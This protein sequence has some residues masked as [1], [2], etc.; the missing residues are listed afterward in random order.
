[1]FLRIRLTR[2]RSSTGRVPRLQRGDAGSSPAVSTFRPS[3]CQRPARTLRTVEAQVRLLP[4][5]LHA[6][7]KLRGR[8]PSCDGG[9][10]WFESSRAYSRGR[11]SMESAGPPARRCRFDSGRPLRQACGVTAS[12]ASSNLAGPGSTPG[13]PAAS[14]RRGPERLGYLW[15]ASGAR[16]RAAVST[17]LPDR[18]PRPRRLTMLLRAEAARLSTPD[19]WSR[20]RIPP[21]A[22]RAPVAQW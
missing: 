2:G 21:G 7:P 11:S 5:A 12:M 3:W 9:G 10:R 4:K 15:R 20:V 8:A 6:R 13:G 1:M 17:P 19:R 14:H 18:T 16:H 22:L